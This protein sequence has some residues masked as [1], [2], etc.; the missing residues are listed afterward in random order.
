M[1][2]QYLWRYIEKSSWSFAN[3]CK[4][5]ATDSIDLSLPHEQLRFSQLLAQ[6]SSLRLALYQLLFP[7]APV[8]GNIQGVQGEGAQPPALPK[9]AIELRDNVP[10][11]T[12]TSDTAQVVEQAKN[13]LLEWFKDAGFVKQLFTTAPAF[14]DLC[15]AGQ[16]MQLAVSTGALAEDICRE[17]K[18]A[19]ALST[20]MTDHFRVLQLLSL[21]NLTGEQFFHI[22]KFCLEQESAPVANFGLQDDNVQQQPARESVKGLF[23]NVLDHVVAGSGRSPDGDFQKNYARVRHQFYGGTA[24]PKLA[25]LIARHPELL[26]ALLGRIDGPRLGRLL[27]LADDKVG[28]L[29]TVA[30]H[31]PEVFKDYGLQ[32]VALATAKMTSSEKK[33]ANRLLRK[34]IVIQ[35]TDV[36]ITGNKT[37]VP[38]A[39]YL[40]RR[41]DYLVGMYGQGLAEWSKTYGRM[42]LPV[43]SNSF[44]RGKLQ[45]GALQLNSLMRP[46]NDDKLIEMAVTNDPY[47]FSKLK[48]SD[49][50]KQQFEDDNLP[51]DLKY[52]KAKHALNVY[53]SGGLF[54]HVFLADD[55]ANLSPNDAY[56]IACDDQLWFQLNP[57]IYVWVMC[58]FDKITL[59][60]FHWFFAENQKLL[61]DTSFVFAARQRWDGI[62]E[63]RD[64]LLQYA[65]IWHKPFSDQDIE[66]LVEIATGEELY[67]L[68]RPDANGRKALDPNNQA[69]LRTFKEQAKVRDRYIQAT[70]AADTF[71]VHDPLMQLEDVKANLTRSDIVR[72]LG[73][74]NPGLQQYC[75]TALQTYAPILLQLLRTPAH[76][77]DIVDV[78]VY[79]EMPGILPVLDAVFN[80]NTADRISDGGAYGYLLL[81]S[82]GAS[83]EVKAADAF[84][85]HPNMLVKLINYLKQEAKHPIAF[86]GKEGQER[87][88]DRINPGIWPSL[89]ELLSHPSIKEA[90]AKNDPD[91]INLTHLTQLGAIR[92]DVF[93]SVVEKDPTFYGGIASKQPINIDFFAQAFSHSV[94]FGVSL[95]GVNTG[96]TLDGLL[97]NVQHRVFAL[98]S[99]EGR[100]QVTAE[101]L[102]ESVNSGGREYITFFIKYPELL[103]RLFNDDTYRVQIAELGWSLVHSVLHDPSAQAVASRMQLSPSIC[104]WMLLSPNQALQNIAVTMLTKKL[105]ENDFSLMTGLMQHQDFAQV[106]P[107]IKE[108]V[109]AYLDNPNF[110]LQLQLVH[111]SWLSGFLRI[112]P[113][114]AKTICEQ[115]LIMVRQVITQAAAGNQEADRFLRANADLCVRLVH[116]QEGGQIN[117][118][119]GVVRYLLSIDSEPLQAGLLGNSGFLSLM[120]KNKLPLSTRHYRTLFSKML[121][122]QHRHLL[123]PSSGYDNNR[124]IRFHL[125]GY[126]VALI[127]SDGPED[128]A[129]AADLLSAIGINEQLIRQLS[130]RHLSKI[131]HQQ[132]DQ[133][134]YLFSGLYHE[135]N[136]DVYVGFVLQDIQYFSSQQLEVIAQYSNVMRQL[137]V[138]LSDEVIVNV[139]SSEAAICSDSFSQQ[140]SRI[141]ALRLGK[142]LT[143]NPD[144]RQALVANQSVKLPDP[145]DVQFSTEQFELKPPSVRIESANVQVPVVEQIPGTQPQHGIVVPVNRFDQPSR[146]ILERM[147]NFSERREN[148]KKIIVTQTTKK[149]SRQ[150][151]SDIISPSEFLDLTL[152]TSRKNNQ[153]DFLCAFYIAGKSLGMWHA[154]RPSVAVDVV[155]RVFNFNNKNAEKRNKLIR[156]NPV[157]KIKMGYNPQDGSVNLKNGIVDCYDGEFAHQF[158]IDFCTHA[159]YYWELIK[160]NKQW[161]DDCLNI[162]L[163]LNPIDQETFPSLCQLVVGTEVG[164]KLLKDEGYRWVMLT[165]Y[166][167]HHGFSAL[168]TNQ[169]SELHGAMQSIFWAAITAHDDVIG[170]MLDAMPDVDLRRFV[171]MFCSPEKQ[172]GFQD[173][174]E[175]FMSQNFNCVKR[176][177]S[178]GDLAFWQPVMEQPNNF[179]LR[180]LNSN[181]RGVCFDDSNLRKIFELKSIE[182]T[183]HALAYMRREEPAFARTLV[184]LLAKVD[185]DT[186]IHVLHTLTEEQVSDVLKEI[187]G[188]SLNKDDLISLLSANVKEIT[189][190]VARKMSE[191]T[192]TLISIIQDDIERCIP[193]NVIKDNII[194]MLGFQYPDF[195]SD[196]HVLLHRLMIEGGADIRNALVDAAARGPILVEVL[197]ALA[198]REYA[199]HPQIVRPFLIALF[200][201][202]LPDSF[203]KKLDYINVSSLLALQDDVVTQKLLGNP[204]ILHK[205]LFMQCPFTHHMLRALLKNFSRGKSLV[206]GDEDEDLQPLLSSFEFRGYAESLGRLLSFE[207]KAQALFVLAVSD[208]NVADQ[209][210]GYARCFL[211]PS[212]RENLFPYL[213]SDAWVTVLNYGGDNV[214]DQFFEDLSRSYYGFNVR[215]HDVLISHGDKITSAHFFKRLCSYPRLFQAAFPQVLQH[216]DFIAQHG[217]FSG[218]VTSLQEDQHAVNCQRW[219]ALLPDKAQETLIEF[220]RAPV[221]LA[222]DDIDR[223]EQLNPPVRDLVQFSAIGGQQQLQP[224][225]TAADYINDEGIARIL[226]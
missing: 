38:I 192:T 121:E 138:C 162:L 167:Q 85:R 52:L 207:I 92:P 29:E 108:C 103:M 12:V 129:L 163:F 91:G 82:M 118:S 214:V 187:A 188:I 80:E 115:S 191:D 39:T 171:D 36:N 35:S 217:S 151:S 172:D 173:Y 196:Y 140:F 147:R 87:H 183:K 176:L 14:I 98:Y 193:L 124:D 135:I 199:E 58:V 169:A 159:D 23:W 19:K 119:E 17:T 180:L 201:V 155:Q 204:N 136:A 4:I 141:H 198:L 54:D 206:R 144:A 7:G 51:A 81:D 16:L 46:G 137:G 22:V 116:S 8:L 72:L 57:W 123:E 106:F 96:L 27:K 149:L 93:K 181:D 222:E 20:Q 40:K 13:K 66:F 95:F 142:L 190:A 112:L 50:W 30:D 11:N 219:L 174:L 128:Q 122:D 5:L 225:Q 130:D 10:L 62:G 209:L 37:S 18:Y 6:S 70:L 120:A 56:V 55:D 200:S 220:S 45:F 203:Y 205:L 111:Q 202:K 21:D 32:L 195:F 74:G 101:Q 184:P 107:Q 24:N 73:S 75:T 212:F 132:L 152:D 154:I 94:E 127:E 179:L 3:F 161:V 223:S 166:V 224:Q 84:V 216:P 71:D 109:S 126:F 33:R 105:E 1:S 83:G 47:L 114:E 90:V 218:F 197:F 97:A 104:I 69:F 185:V 99:P 157:F 164:S 165:Y 211:E 41:A 213:D 28:F 153:W 134:G 158:V 67:R 208:E 60:F 2:A 79:Q 65:A 143:R 186:R 150:S 64:H 63:F 86:V 88:Y 89:V 178:S 221:Y 125:L 215:L 53:H 131:F 34:R 175:H 78:W 76:S 15:N 210:R 102:L 59:K 113:E 189:E 177:L 182:M 42:L 160:N 25:D 100:A 44:L 68:V 110:V 156:S 9:L 139:L 31:A 170:L 148:V 49:D 145:V 133:N 146:Q 194:S 48:A 77:K 61:D 117:M 43:L 226:N 26:K 168:L